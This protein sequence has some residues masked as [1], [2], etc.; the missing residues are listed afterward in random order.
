MAG[1]LLLAYELHCFDLVVHFLDSFLVCVVIITVLSIMSTLYSG[2][3][4]FMAGRKGRERALF[5]YSTYGQ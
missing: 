4:G 5:S 3:S 1:F 2:G